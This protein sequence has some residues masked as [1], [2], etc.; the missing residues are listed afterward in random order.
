M[1]TKTTRRAVPIDSKN[2]KKKNQTNQRMKNEKNK[3]TTLE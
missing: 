1:P 3:K 2:G